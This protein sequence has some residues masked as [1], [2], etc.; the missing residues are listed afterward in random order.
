MGRGKE[1]FFFPCHGCLGSSSR[2][3]IVHKGV[4]PDKTSE[5]L[6]FKKDI[7]PLKGSLRLPLTHD[8]MFNAVFSGTFPKSGYDRLP[9][10]LHIAIMDC[11]LFPKGDPRN[12]EGFLREFHL[13]DTKNHQIYIGNFRLDIYRE[14]LAEQPNGRS[15]VKCGAG[16]VSGGH[17]SGEICVL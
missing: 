16:Y 1:D 7:L 5:V 17:S 13:Q 10:V 9:S 2:Q 3:R 11:D 6:D 14:P 4:S 12:T 15:E 8:Y